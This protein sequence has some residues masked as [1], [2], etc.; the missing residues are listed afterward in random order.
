[1]KQG[2]LTT[3]QA[4]LRIFGLKGQRSVQPWATPRVRSRS[5]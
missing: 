5:S 4:A 1:L 3:R 2:R